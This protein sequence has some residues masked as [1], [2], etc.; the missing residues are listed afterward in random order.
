MTGE[1]HSP[2]LARLILGLLLPERYRDNQLGDLEEEFQARGR[3][4]G[5]RTARRAGIGCRLRPRCRAAVAGQLHSGV[6]GH[7]GRSDRDAEGRL[8]S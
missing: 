1:P 4:D 8:G 7:E 2:R 5:W 6:Q 3:R